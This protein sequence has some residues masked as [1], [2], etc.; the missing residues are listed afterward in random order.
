MSV[1]PVIKRPSAI[2]CIS[3]ARRDPMP[4]Q[5]LLVRRCRGIMRRCC[6][7]TVRSLPPDCDVYVTDWHNA[8]DIPVSCGKF[9]IEDYTQ[10]IVDFIRHLGPDTNVIA[11]C[12]PAPL[13]LAA[14]ALLAA[15]DPWP[16]PVR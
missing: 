2:S 14:T 7:S 15:E 9:D 13:T 6:A 16:S 4:R 11:V 5:V 8:R 1:E 10:Y 12:Q 3:V